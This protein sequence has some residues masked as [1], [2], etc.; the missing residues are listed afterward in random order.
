MH[1]RGRRET[2]VAAAALLVAAVAGGAVALGGA[3]LTGFGEATSTVR[4]VIRDSA[5]GASNVA[6][7]SRSGRRLTIAEIYERAAPG[8]VLVTTTTEVAPEKDPFFGFE[9]PGSEIQRALG[10][11]FVYDKTGLIVTNDHVIAGADKVQVSFSNKDSMEA[12]IV[13]RDPATDLALLKVNADSRAL[14]PLE[15]GDSDRARVGDDVLAIGNPFGRERSA[16]RGI[17]SA[18]QRLLSSPNGDY[19]IDHVIQ[20]DA[21]I[22]R[23]NSGGPLLDAQGR[24]VGVTSAIE[25]GDT[26]SQ[27]NVGIGYAIPVNTVS[28]VVSQLREKGRVDHPF[29]GI[30]SRPI[31]PDVAK[32]FRLPVDRGLMVQSVFPDTGA[33]RAGLRGGD[34]RVVLAGES[35][36]LGGDIIVK[37]D[38]V[39]LTSTQGLR[40]VVSRKEPGDTVS[41]EIYRGDDRR[42]LRIKLGRQ[43]PTPQE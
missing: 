16:S 3:A 26:G 19:T 21:Q 38:G 7:E 11:G 5:P 39:E 25:T 4:E 30:E 2:L 14:Q 33:A 41:V 18:V 32:L 37:V 15:L 13:G 17:V 12:R 8:V 42:T 22:N 36:M 34:T 40:E 43:P 35:Y 28:D 9:V 10:S 23:G 6:S 29:I 20:T 1:L 24:V 31:E 27:G